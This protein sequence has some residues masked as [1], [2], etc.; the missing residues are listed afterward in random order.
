MAIRQDQ[1]QL[2]IDFITDDSRAL[3]KTLVE[4]KKYTA[5]IDKANAQIRNYNTEL[6]K[7]NTTEERRLVLQNKIA[8]A[9]NTVAANLRKV[10]EAGK[11][12]EKINL[13]NVA[14][15]QLVARSRQLTQA[16]RQIPQS[17]PEFKKLQTEL[18]KVNTQ[19]KE[20]SNNA[21]GASAPGGKGLF[22]S[23]SSLITGGARSI[24]IIGGI[25][26]AISALGGA[27]RRASTLEQLTISFETFLG[28]AEKAQGVIKDLKDFEV[29]TPFESDQVNK[30]GRALLAFGVTTNDLIPTLTRVGD[31]AAG[32][33]KDFN[34]LALIYGKAKTQGIVQ[35]EELNQLA[36]A[37]IP[38]YGELAKVLNVNENQ[39]R[40]LGEQ[41]K[42]QFA[43]LDQVF[44]NLTSEGGRFTNLMERQSQSLGGLYS[45]LKSAF[46]ILLEQL[47]TAFAPLL[48]GILQLL[49]GGLKG[50]QVLTT[51]VF[52]AIATGFQYVVEGAQLTVGFFAKEIPGAI[53][54]TVAA[55][56]SIPILGDAI[57]VLLTPIRL[58]IDS[59]ESLSATAKGVFASLADIFATGGKNVGAVYK[60]TR[61]AAL[62]EERQIAARD[63]AENARDDLK[64][65]KEEQDK[66]KAEES[67]A[68]KARAAEQKKIREENQKKLEAALALALKAQEVAQ[69]RQELLLENARFKGEIDEAT[70]Q[71]RLSDITKA[72]LEQRLEIYRNFQRDQVNEALEIQNQLAAGAAGQGLK[73]APVAALP[74]RNTG[75]PSSGADTQTG[76][77]LAILKLGT[78]ARQAALR[79]RFERLLITEQDYELKRLELKRQAIDEEIAIL[80]TS[81]E[82]QTALVKKKEQERYEIEK[83]IGAK[84][85]DNERRTEEMKIKAQQAGLGATADL[86]SVAADLLGQDEKAR[87]KNASAIKAFQSAQVITNGVLEVQKIWASVAEFGPFG[88]VIGGILTAVAVGRSAL[89]LSKIRKAKFA[90]GGFT[91]Q[92]YGAPDSTGFKP[93][94]VV[95]EGEYVAPKWVVNDPQTAPV[96]RY[97]EN[98]RLRGY[99][100]G[101]LVSVNTSPTPGPSLGTAAAPAL[102]NLDQFV[103]A[104]GMFQQIAEN[105]PRNVKSSVVLTELEAQQSSLDGVR[106]AA[107]I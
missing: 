84:R 48:K 69:Q 59:F 57:T 83:E 46:S 76:T 21:K 5:E 53:S 78:D 7:K 93:A 37:G 44:K 14:P 13:S 12:A 31:V 74:G 42:I 70:Y 102:A 106:S 30:A 65:T 34:E 11:A 28:S 10:A 63:R 58:V 91:G 98:R 55:A 43:D 24:P 60:A 73:V 107:S 96:I 17:A 68:A 6:K 92:G 51:P 100:T 72:A 87:K 90:G 40:K 77:D 1:V 4:T 56:E 3:A 64:L 47:G 67:K 36:E 18:A 39:I 105:F 19:L 79:D 66:I 97:L 82:D 89:A 50:L 41:G 104:V 45:T 9:E 29:K 16:L 85:L 8:A 23:I 88:A 33:G 32:T 101:G 54:K 75:A 81:T 38:I 86:F 62:N 15:A 61:E 95:H 27:A 22:G 94:G 99:A 49:I 80:K 103:A 35:G 26:T 20:V 2:R 71:Q 52:S 25:V